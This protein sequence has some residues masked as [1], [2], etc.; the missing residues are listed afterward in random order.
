[1]DELS[2]SEASRLRKELVETA[3]HARGVRSELVL[4]AVRSVPRESFLPERLREFA[5]EDTALP[6]EEGRQSRSLISSPL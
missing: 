3:I 6:I 2:K 5:Y 4:D 1:M